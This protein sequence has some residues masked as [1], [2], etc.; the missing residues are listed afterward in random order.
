MWHKEPERSI[1]C[2]F[3][4]VFRPLGRRVGGRLQPLEHKVDRQL[5]EIQ[6]GRQVSFALPGSSQGFPRIESRGNVRRK[7]T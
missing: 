6:S 3:E 2:L 1:Q 7:H 4:D 5:L